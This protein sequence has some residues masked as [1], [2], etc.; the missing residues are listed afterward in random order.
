MSYRCE[1]CG[2][3]FDKK[4]ALGGHMRIH[5]E[6]AG[7]HITEKNPYECSNCGKEFDSKRAL[8]GHMNAHSDK[9]NKGQYGYRSPENPGPPDEK[10][11][12]DEFECSKCGKVFESLPSYAGHMNSH[13][14]KENSGQFGNR[15][16]WNKGMSKD[17]M[18]EHYPDGFSFAYWEGK[19]SPKKEER[20]TVECKGCGKEFI[21]PHYSNQ[22]YCSFH[23]YYK[24]NRK[25]T[26]PEAKFIELC[27]K[28]D[29]P[30]KYVGDGEFWIENKNPDFVNCNGKKI[31]VEVLGDYWHTE[32]EFK[33]RQELFQQY[34]WKCIGIWEH[35]IMSENIDKQIVKKVKEVDNYEMS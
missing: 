13:S 3:V 12:P 5:S 26:A 10:K 21:K 9:Q 7:G 27:D 14:D 16:P 31:A 29:L 17:E 25:P 4:Q 1:E 30:Y 8:S 22:K 18:L 11:L 6:K 33:E 15:S 35:E 32:E 23:C 24:N 28:F 34:G 2:K 20:I 19:E